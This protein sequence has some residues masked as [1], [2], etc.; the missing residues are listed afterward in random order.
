MK[1]GR[2]LGVAH[3]QAIGHIGLLFAW[4]VDTA[5]DGD[6]SAYDAEDIAIACGWDGDPAALIAA[7]VDLRWL[8]ETDHGLVIHDWMER[9]EAHA[10]ARKEKKR[11]EKKREAVV[12]ACTTR[13]PRVH[14]EPQNVPTRARE[15]R[16]EEREERDLSP[17]EKEGAELKLALASPPQPPAATVLEIECAGKVPTFAVTEAMI[18]EW[19]EIFPGVDVPAIVR[20]AALWQQDNPRRR[21]TARGL[22]SWLATQWLAK[23]QD[24]ATRADRSAR[25]PPPPRRPTIAQE[26]AADA[27]EAKKHETEAKRLGSLEARR[28]SSG[29]LPR[30]DSGDIASVGALIERLQL[31]G[32]RGSSQAVGDG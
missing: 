2:R 28:L 19:R 32:R 16:G 17:S 30:T 18:A 26:L 29:A 15:R 27:E 1:L 20:R 13:A 8:D 11:R 5:P 21:K 9:A 31:P 24:E 7:L 12:H 6:L 14:H 3:A 22:K 10:R 4:A 23:A 25:S